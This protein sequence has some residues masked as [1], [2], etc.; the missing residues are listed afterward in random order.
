[1][2]TRGTAHRPLIAPDLPQASRAAVR[3]GIL[4]NFVDQ[5]DI[6]LPVTAL[7]PALP[8]LAG[9]GA[10]GA[11]AAYVVMATL[12]GRPLGAMI[13][14][15]ISDRVGRTS[16]T[17]V[18][19]AG[20]AACTLGIA[21]VPTHEQIGM[22][23]IALVIALRFVG[24]VFLAGEYTS[25]IPLAMEWSRPR[26]RGKASGLIMA[27]S[28]SA[29]ATIALVTLGLLT[30]L[31]PEAYAAWGW[32]LSFLAG[33]LASVA[34]LVYYSRRVADAPVQHKVV[35]A[36]PTGVRPGLRDVLAGRWAGPFWQVFGLMSGLWIMTNMTVIVLARRLASDVGLTASGV[37]TAMAI[38][39]VGQA[40]VM[41]LAGHWSTALGRRRFFVIWGLAGLVGGPLLWW[42]TI[43]SGGSAVVAGFAAAALQI[44]TVTAYG[45]VGAYINER[46]PTTVRATAYGTAYSLSIVVPALYPYYLPTLEQWLG[47]QGAPVALLALGA[48]LVTGCG[49]LGPRL[50]RQ[51]LD[52]DLEVVADRQLVARMGESS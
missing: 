36:T 27:M 15:R 13:F 16:T 32:R 11:T 40:V 38:A 51:E 43:R 7:A 2:S 46:F 12:I 20:T 50:S 35:A 4:G 14:G 9:H 3:G 34:M 31:G 48:V 33:A 6:F 22:W 23:A 25:A 49:A 5:F 52:A 45:P 19:I 26:E 18:A 39:S 44:V 42:L 21:L 37:A 1:M 17:R 41:A 24:G 10:I 30:V 28:P 47:H 29:Q 8:S